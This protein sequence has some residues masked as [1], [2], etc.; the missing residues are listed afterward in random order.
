MNCTIIRSI[1]LY[2]KWT[3]INYKFKNRILGIEF[4]LCQFHHMEIQENLLR[5][6]RLK[7]IK[8]KDKEKGGKEKGKRRKEKIKRWKLK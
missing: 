2:L 5:D 3:Y 7:E 8:K 1:D 4:M 6:K